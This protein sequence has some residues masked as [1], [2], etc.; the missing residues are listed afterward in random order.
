MSKRWNP[1]IMFTVLCGGMMAGC[2]DPYTPP[3]SKGDSRFLVIDGVVN[4]TEGSAT[5]KIS[6]AVSLDN[7]VLSDPVAGAAVQIL[8]D[9]DAAVTLFAED[10]GVYKAYFPFRSGSRYRVQVDL[11]GKT[12]ESEPATMVSNVPVD[13]LRY[14]AGEDALRVRVYAHDETGNGDRYF[15]YSYDATYEYRSPYASLYTFNGGVPE[16]REPGDDIYSCWTTRPSSRILLASTEGLDRPVVA[17][18]AIEEIP[19]G[20]KRLWF[21]YSLLVRQHALDEAAYL[22][23]SRLKDVSQ[24]LGGLFDPVPFSVQGNIRCVSDPDEQVLGY[25]SGG[26]VEEKRI[27]IANTNLPLGYYQSGIGDCTESYVRIAELESIANRSVLLTRADYLGIFIIGY[28]YTS[29]VCGDCRF[30]G[31][32]NQRPPFM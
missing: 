14:E 11:D 8:D 30:G 5:V 31:G 28:F 1:L 9:A 25:F 10:V 15:R 32:T 19:K 18:L 23:W 2:L 27:T 13:S 24:S 3:K 16:Y 29:P 6:R 22:Y 17:G 12:Y 7:E 26:E 4:T 21:R 20:D